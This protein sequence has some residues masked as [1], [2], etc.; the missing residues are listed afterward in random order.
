MGLDAYH[1]RPPSLSKWAAEVR[2]DTEPTWL[3]KDI[4]P[5]DNLILCSGQAKEAKKSWF[6]MLTALV[7]A[8]GK[9]VAGLRCEAAMPVLYIY[10]EGARQATLQRFEALCRGHDLPKVDDIENLY[11][12]HRGH[13]MLDDKHC[14]DQVMAF[15][16]EAG[17][18]LIYIDT[19]AKS[20]AADENNAQH[21]GIAIREAERLR[22]CGTTVVLVHHPR[23]AAPSL[24]LG[25]TGT[26]EPDNDLR[27]SGNLAGSYEMHWAIRSYPDKNSREPEQVMIISSKE[28]ERVAYSYHWTFDPP[29]TTELETARLTFEKRPY[30][31]YIES[32]QSRSK[33]DSSELWSA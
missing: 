9:S 11:I 22:D 30:L 26:P 4:L 27:G 17:I 1:F 29:N 24:S 25:K 32:S 21:I 28:A 3:I 12:C 5:S 15:V 20:F 8:T 10:R 18:K 2:Q 7:L 6:S 33:S 31:P 19:F 14:V 13:F 23:K 16:K